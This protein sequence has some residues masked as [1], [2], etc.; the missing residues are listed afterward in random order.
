MNLFL[1]IIITGM[2]FFTPFS[3]AG[4]EAW[5]FTVLQGLLLLAAF[6]LFFSRRVLIF[7][8]LFKV[9]FAA[10]FILI[11]LALV[12]SCFPQTLLS[13]TL[14]WYPVTLMQL[15]TLEHA[16][17]FV[18]YLGVVIVTV[19]VYQSWKEVQQLAWT[20]VICAACVEL[21]ELIFPNGEYIAFLTG[22]P[23]NSASVGPFLNR[24]HAGMFFVMNALVALGF[25][26]T[27]Q[28]QYKKLFTREQ[29]ASF[30]V[31]Q[32]CLGLLS[33][34]LMLAAIFTRSRGAMLS[35]FIGLFAYAFLCIWCVPSQVRRRLKRIFY[36]L[37]LLV[38]SSAW[39]YTH[40]EDINEFA[41]RQTGASA[42]IRQMMYHAAGHILQKYPV[43][44]I[45]IGA[46]PVV[47][48]EYTDFDV[49]QYIER[50]HN[51]WLEITL[52]VGFVGATLIL[53][54][55]GWFAWGALR[56]LKQL[57]TRKQFVFASLLSALLAMCV[58]SC[59]DF[60]FFIPGCALVFF[61]LLGAINAPT[62]HHHHIHVWR[63]GW[64]GATI[65]FVVL[66]AACYVP[67]RKTLCWRAFVFGHGLK[68]EAKLASY[69]KGLSYYPGP[70]YAVRLGNSYYNTA[71]HAKD[72][73]VKM[74]YFEQAQNLA[75]QY[76]EQYPK[77]KELSRLYMRA[78][79]QLH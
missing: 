15:Y 57:D 56:R 53:A 54:V 22:T 67:L 16:S 38:V 8:S 59:V 42:E 30:I 51:D 26:F 27:H 21:C 13:D 25:F 77:D 3:F 35:L 44:G 70:H 43:W 11:G 69:E 2:I 72:P 39:V 1:K 49:H 28:L 73:F 19:Q 33:V 14:P 60:H 58:G 47:I 41:Q 62:F 76:L 12:Q 64:L 55:L 10:F 34:G 61:I 75:T 24:N 50:L 48:T 20:L 74:F 5:A 68:T 23:A 9:V 17:L 6:M 36:T 29:R 79:H 52:G 45:G 4:T 66:I 63:M 46:M 18:T 40:V 7:P 31:Q 32:I 78:E 65:L 71:V 37:L